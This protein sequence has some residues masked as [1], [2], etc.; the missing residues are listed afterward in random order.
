MVG[1]SCA[2]RCLTKIHD[3]AEDADIE[4]DGELVEYLINKTIHEMIKAARQAPEIIL[5]DEGLGQLLIPCRQKVFQLAIV[6]VRN[7]LLS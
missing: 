6:V 1:S 3:I 2:I 7:F 5:V 4:E